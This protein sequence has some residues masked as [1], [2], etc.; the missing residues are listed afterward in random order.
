MFKFLVSSRYPSWAA[1]LLLSALS[2]P[3][4]AQNVDDG[5]FA[6]SIKC[7]SEL[8]SRDRAELKKRI[9]SE[10]PIAS[11]IGSIDFRI[12]WIYAQ[13]DVANINCPSNR[14]NFAFAFWMPDLRALA[15]DTSTIRIDKDRFRPIEP[16]RP[17]PSAVEYLVTVSVWSHAAAGGSMARFIRERLANAPPEWRE[18]IEYGL[19]VLPDEPVYKG[20]EFPKRWYILNDDNDLI[21][22]CDNTSKPRLSSICELRISLN[23]SK[24]TLA[25]TIPRERISDTY[26]I[27]D[28]VKRFLDRWRVEAPP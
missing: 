10:Y 20:P 1:A 25:I 9:P 6:K 16:G 2:T 21:L 3:G 24:I 13:A 4:M 14:R 26:L 22:W 5:E 19:K 12:P 27:Y 18:K 23:K 17:E 15:R 7:K 28:S 11:A 8:S